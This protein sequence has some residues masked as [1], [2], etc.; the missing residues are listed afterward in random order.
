M[1]RNADQAYGLKSGLAVAAT[2]AFAFLAPSPALAQ[3]SKADQPP[4]RTAEETAADLR[5]VLDRH[6]AESLCEDPDTDLMGS[7]DPVI[8]QLSKTAIL[9]AIPCTAGAYNVAY[10]LYRRET[11]EIGGVKT[12][13]FATWSG[14]YGWGGTDLLFN[15][16]ADG[17]RLSAFYKGRGLG[18]CGTDGQWVWRDYAYRLERFA[19][20]DTCNGVTAENWPVIFA[21]PGN[22]KESGS[23]Q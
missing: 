14:E 13:Y 9:Y 15:I 11:G 5:L 2:V 19:A 17:P 1:R 23:T 10:R 3:T 18:D 8:A 12:L 7:F 6:R 20:Q 21:F 22:G 4:Q 16:E